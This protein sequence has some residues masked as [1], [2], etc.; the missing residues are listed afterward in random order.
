[1]APKKHSHEL[2]RKILSAASSCVTGAIIPMC[3]ACEIR[4]YTFCATLKAEELD[5]LQAIVRQI[6]VMP[7]QM[8]F[9]EGDDASNV[10]NVLTGVLKLYKMLPD[11]RQQIT[12]FTYRGDFL[13]ITSGNGFSYSAEAI[14]DVTLCRYPRR[15]L[16]RLIDQ[17]PRL[18]GWL[19]A[20]T[21]DELTAAQDQI[22]LLGCKT[23][24]EKLASFLLQLAMRMNGVGGKDKTIPVPM[25]RRDIGDYLGLRVETVSRTFRRFKTEGLITAPYTGHI[26]IIRPTELQNI[27]DGM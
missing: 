15:Q 8:L 25:T 3:A 23:A 11:G 16:H 10:Y 24:D 13:G 1:M 18:Q 7:R 6:R 27:A 17:F 9:H 4:D 14:T 20:I 12:G 2:S 22:L 5:N 19:L 26:S 21:T